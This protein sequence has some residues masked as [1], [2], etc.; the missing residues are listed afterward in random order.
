MTD[1]YELSIFLSVFLGGWFVIG[2]LIWAYLE[3]P[4]K[5]T[6]KRRQKHANDPWLIT[7]Y[8]LSKKCDKAYG[9]Y[10]E[11]QDE[12]NH[13]IKELHEKVLYKDDEYLK[14]LRN[15]ANE[16]EKLVPIYQS[17]FEKIDEELSKHINDNKKQYHY[18]F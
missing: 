6:Y 9:L 2:F 3:L 15:K 1:F 8:E 5:I 13:L 16:L 14:P 18:Y 4:D 7:Y 17:E 10:R 11:T 12:Y